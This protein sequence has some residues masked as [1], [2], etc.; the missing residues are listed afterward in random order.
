MSCKHLHGSVFPQKET[1]FMKRLT[2][3]A[4]A[5]LLLFAA[6]PSVC[7]EEAPVPIYT[8][9][10]LLSVANDPSGSYILMEDLDLTGVSWEGLDFRGTFDGNGHAILNLSITQPGKET[11]AS[12][13]GNL[14]TYDT[15]FA[16]FFSTLIDARVTNLHLFNVQALVDT[17]VPCFLSGLAG[18][19][20]N[21][22]IQGCT[23]SG[24]LE[25]RAFDRMFGVGGIVGYG[26]GVVER[27]TA[28][29]TLICTDTDPNTTDEQFMGGIFSTGFVDVIDCTVRIDGYCSEYG[30][31]HNGGI[32]G[33]YMQEPLGNGRMGSFIG[34]YVEGKITFFERNPDRRAYCGPYAGEVLASWYYF[35]DNRESFIRDERTDYTIE[36][37]PEMCADPVYDNEVIAPGCDTYGY[38]RHTCRSCSYTYTD[39]YTLF[40]HSLTQWTLVEAPTTETEGLSKA[41]CDLC[42]KEFS[43]AE[44]MLEAPPTEATV[45]TTVPTEPPT[46][47]PTQP[48]VPETQ[49]VEMPAGS[50]GPPVLVW[51]LL[52]VG[53]LLVSVL[54][55]LPVFRKQPRGGKYLK[56]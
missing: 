44:P 10:D 16:G 22:T 29:V 56:K 35:N 28:D 1:I 40:S 39:S 34:N 37:R 55:L 20:E 11:A 9:E 50:D 21:S 30:Y 51:I 3:I 18:F 12:Y 6:V 26:S 52:A 38:T 46:E 14:K 4:L 7:A 33:M 23:V 13:D 8:V 5:L 43:R 32:T 19:C 24:I 25:L 47:A 17:D 45:P 41:A 42:G 53:V 27:C 54:F 2:A 15:Y 49:P 36:L 48:P 31:V